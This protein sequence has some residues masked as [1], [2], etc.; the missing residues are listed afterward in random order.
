VISPPI[1]INEQLPAGVVAGLDHTGKVV[2][3]VELL[4]VRRYLTGSADEQYD[5]SEWQVSNAEARRKMISL[6]WRQTNYVC[7][8]SA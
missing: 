4:P 7:W 3:C 2:I 6:A 1:N 8:G 5:V